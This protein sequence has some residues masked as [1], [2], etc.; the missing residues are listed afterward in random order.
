MEPLLKITRIPMEYELT[1]QHARLER[2]QSR[3]PVVEISRQRGGF[4]M[5]S[6]PARLNL[7]TYEARNSIS[8][9]TR[10]AIYQNAQK[11]IRAAGEA[12]QSYSNEAAQMRWSRPGEGGEMLSQIF[13]Q[14]V[15]MPTGQFQLTFLPSAGVDITYQAGNL[16]TSYQMDRLT[17]NLK[18]NNSDVEYIPGSVNIEVTQYP[19]VLIE[20]MGTPLFVPPSAA[21]F[22]T[23]ETVDT[24]A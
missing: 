13:E 7:D 9:S 24:V 15:Q 19:D 4:K 3:P 22:F 10:T 6:Q 23:G 18:L 11:G 20:Y 8:P 17:F 16:T 2:S 14:R 21:E 5:R 1:I 12:A